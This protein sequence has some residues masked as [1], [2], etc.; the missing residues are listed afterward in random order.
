MRSQHGVDTEDVMSAIEELNW[1]TYESTSGADHLVPHL[2][3]S[4]SKPNYLTRIVVRSDGEKL[5][6][7][8]FEAGRVIVGRAPDNDIYVKSKFVSRHHAQIITDDFGCT[9]EDLNS[10]NGVYI[11]K[12]R[13]KKYLLRD[14]DIVTLGLHELVYTDL[15]KSRSD[16]EDS[17]ASE[18]QG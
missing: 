1:K 11:G 2:V 9:I 18:Q 10:T 7:H 16:D 6:E 4:T 17:L 14:G 12:D 5:S 15:R 8:M 13:V 3:S